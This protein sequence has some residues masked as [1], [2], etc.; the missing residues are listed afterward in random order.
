MITLNN[1]TL[2][3]AQE[4]LLWIREVHSAELTE[5]IEEIVVHQSLTMEGLRQEVVALVDPLPQA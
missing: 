3:P 2:D 5:V 4:I 1:R